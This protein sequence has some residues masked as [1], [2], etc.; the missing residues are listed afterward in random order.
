MR[1]ILRYALVVILLL[2]A[3]WE[4]CADWQAWV[5]SDTQRVLRE[6]PAGSELSVR[7]NAARNEWESFQIFVRSDEE[8]RSVRIVPGD[9][10]GPE[11]AVLPAADAQ[12]YREQQLR[13][14]VGTYRNKEFRPGFYPDPLIPARHPVTGEPLIGRF[15]CMPFDLAASTTHGF[16]ID[17][18]VPADAKGGIY[19]GTYRVSAATGDPVEISVTLNVWDFRLPDTPTF[20]T[21][22]GSPFDQ[23]QSYY[24]RRSEQGKESQPEDWNAVFQQVSELLS[25]NRIN[26]TPKQGVLVP[27][28]QPDGTFAIPKEQV[29]AM[30]A[31][32]DR[33]HINAFQT[34]HP[35][36]V[37]KD[38]DSERD[39]LHA[40]LHAYDRAW[41]ELARPQVIFYTY[42]RD[43]PNNEEDYRYVQK[44]GRAVRS[45]KSVV[46]VL[47]V[48]QTWPE[49]PAWGDLYGAVDIW[50]P[51]FSLFK[52]ESA[53]KRQALGETIWTYTALCQGEPTP[54]W[55]TDMP[56]LN[57]RV[58][59]WIAWRYRIRGILYWGGMCYWNDVED[60]W[61][62]PETLDRRKDRAE[63]VYNG[64]GSLLY[65]GR[66]VGY[67]GV[68][69]SMRLKALRDSIEDYEY[70]AILERRGLAAQA[71]AIVRPLAQSFFQWEKNPQAYEVART[72]LAEWIIATAKP[73]EPK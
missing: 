53:V 24:R 71:D 16:W 15:R 36:S 4:A 17:L 49:N 43:E 42:L 57:Y 44:W 45:A 46:Q 11:G 1:I 23:L 10:T 58:P 26:A 34:P 48:E 52:P 18:K 72:K 62:Q 5:V 54:W 67:D 35:S 9:L 69:P 14:G 60:P 8:V 28:E 21:A 13:I 29:D 73:G 37:I 2:G 39:R 3:A 56:L 66:A 25:Q 19:R 65:P 22:M 27:A 63:L 33:Y 41:K 47:V 20:R 68:A 6:D 31:F 51:L 61:K 55:Q 12:I 70:M 59:A 50:C 30:R 38:P 32:V 40:W 7:L 64:E